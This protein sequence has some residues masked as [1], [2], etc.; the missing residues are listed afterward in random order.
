MPETIENNP[1]QPNIHFMGDET[2]KKPPMITITPDAF[3]VRGKLVP[4]DE[5]E[6]QKV[7]NAFVSWLKK[8]PK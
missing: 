3:Y 1:Q 8:M 7:Y 2:G 6:A 5:G 4:Q